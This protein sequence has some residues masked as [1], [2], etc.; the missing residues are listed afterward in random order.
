MKRLMIGAALIALLAS[1]VASARPDDRHSPR[2]TDQQQHDGRQWHP[3]ARRSDKG[4]W[5]NGHHVGWGRDRGNKARWGRG[6][7]MGYNDWRNARRINYR[8]YNLRQPPRGYEWRRSNDRFVM[9]SIANGVIISVI[10]S[11]GR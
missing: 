7:Q 6:Q 8:T 1:P 5:D 11:N 3:Q 2:A 9:A 4:H 10:L